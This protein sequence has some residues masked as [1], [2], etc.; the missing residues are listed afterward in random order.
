MLTPKQLYQQQLQN[1][2]WISDINQNAVMHALDQLFHD[3]H[4]SNQPFQLFLRYF[5]K[6]K[7]KT[8]SLYIWGDVGRGKTAL[9]DLFYGSLTE[10]KKIR[11]HYYHF[12][13]TIHQE[14]QYF[15]GHTDPLKHIAH[16]LSKKY[17]IIVLD[18]FFVVDIADAMILGRFLKFLFEK[19]VILV[20]TSNLHPESLYK[21]GLHR[22]RF[23]PA[24]AL[25][26]NYF[27]IINMSGMKDHRIQAIQYNQQYSTYYTP[28]NKATKE[29]MLQH[30]KQLTQHQMSHENQSLY[31]ESRWIQ[32]KKMTE[33][34]VWFDFEVLC[35][36]PRSA[37]DYICLSE[38]FHTIFLDNIPILDR[39]Y[40]NASRRFIQ[41]VDELYDQKV[42]LII[43]AHCSMNTLYQGNKLKFEYNRT[44]SRLKEMQSQYNIQKAN[45]YDDLTQTDSR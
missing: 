34:V 38:K 23:M 18:E 36:S 1:N 33:K 39:Q 37:Q 35:N 10:V 40:E 16:N 13:Q 8:R 42:H 28:L 41:L 31:I 4:K 5:F 32:T 11:L 12:M 7:N 26:K 9:V 20:V 21:K 44:L 45:P 30:F 43:A 15:K 14:I 29:H 3:I 17:Q 24:I 2:Q 27:D 19:G 25:I 6:I 22:N